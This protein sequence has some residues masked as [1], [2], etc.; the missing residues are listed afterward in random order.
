MSNAWGNH[1]PLLSSSNALVVNRYFILLACF[2]PPLQYL[3]FALNFIGKAVSF[4]CIFINNKF[5]I[6]LE[7][8]MMASLLKLLDPVTWTWKYYCSRDFLSS[9]KQQWTLLILNVITQNN[10]IGVL[11][12][13]V[14]PSLFSGIRWLGSE[15]RGRI[16]YAELT[17]A[18]LGWSYVD[19]EMTAWFI[20]PVSYLWTVSCLF[21][22]FV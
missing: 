2:I 22:S 12:I 7:F 15:R 6:Q 14:F 21:W 19:K 8:S 20:C 10:V 4:A 1:F 3:L 13:W 5:N 17:E 18:L 16:K 11:W 9:L